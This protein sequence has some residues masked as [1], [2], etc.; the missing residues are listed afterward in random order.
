MQTVLLFVAVVS[1]D[2]LDYLPFP[3]G[4]GLVSC[5]KRDETDSSIEQCQD[6]CKYPKQCEY[7]KCRSCSMCKPC[8]SSEA[9]DTNFESCEE[10]CK[11]RE[12][13]SHCKCG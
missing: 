3:H 8:S 7:C 12:H 11:V 4:R 9:D 1:V 6:W 5:A 13:C 10:W 2:F